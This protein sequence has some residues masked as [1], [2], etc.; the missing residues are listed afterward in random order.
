[1]D[2]RIFP[3]KASVACLLAA[4]TLAGCASDRYYLVS[5]NDIRDLDTTLQA[6]K[7][8]LQTLLMS[9]AQQHDTLLRQ[10][11]L[12]TDTVL[13]AID[14]R[15]KPPECPP[16]PKPAACHPDQS[17]VTAEREG[18]ANRLAGKL[19]VGEREKFLLIGP[20]FTFTARID[21]GAETSSLDARNIQRFER[22]GQNWVRFD[23]PNPEQDGELHTLER[24]IA[25]NVRIIQSNEEDYER[26]PVVELQFAIGN[27]RQ[28]AEFTLSNR[29]HMSHTVLI[30]RN[31]LRDVMLIDV[32]KEFA[33]ELP[34]SLTNGE[35]DP[36]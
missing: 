29:E 18:Y 11:R 17:A 13:A 4:M 36:S 34:T 32:G 35:D 25:R 27:H 6:Q 30:G 14:E 9:S 1:M 28:K 7:T 2:A 15:V 3:G 23:I 19:V 8:G 5:N 22:D 20:Q 16:P 33:T 12:A 31:I 21:S 24:E 10:N 26:R